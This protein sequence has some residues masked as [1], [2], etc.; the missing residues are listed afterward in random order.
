V[1]KRCC[2]EG[3]AAKETLREAEDCFYGRVTEDMN[4]GVLKAT[5]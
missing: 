3:G 2:G 1:R 4:H 5:E